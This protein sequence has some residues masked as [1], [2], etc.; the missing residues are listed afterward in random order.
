MSFPSQGYVPT[1]VD[2]TATQ[3]TKL[4]PETVIGE[5]TG[6]ILANEE[7]FAVDLSPT[8][9]SAGEQ[10]GFTIIV[11]VTDINDEE[12]EADLQV[13]FDGGANWCNVDTIEDD[14]LRI[15]PQDRSGGIAVKFGDL[16]NI[17]FS[18]GLTIVL[19]RVGER[20]C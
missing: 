10:H 4:G 14:D 19:L 12:G 7:V 3:K 5:R 6:A 11:C 16:F 8:G 9:L 18:V 20:Q 13:T 17:R 1:E 15:F 2:P